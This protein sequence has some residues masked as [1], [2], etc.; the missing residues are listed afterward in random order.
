MS[1]SI[2]HLEPSSNLEQPATTQKP[3]IDMFVLVG[4]GPSS[5]RPGP[6]ATEST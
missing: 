4:S 1:L 3:N 6:A 2:P 5:V